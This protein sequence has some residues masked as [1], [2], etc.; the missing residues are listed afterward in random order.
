MKS[1]KFVAIAIFSVILTFCS[2]KN[3]N[4]VFTEAQNLIA[5]EKYDEAVIK[6]EE[7]VNEFP[8]SAKADSSLFE[9][10]KLYQGQVIKN[11]RPKESLKKAVETYKKVF[12]D[13]PNSKLAESSIF[14]AGFILANELKEFKEAGKMYNLYIQKYPNGELADDAKIELQ[15]LGKS[16]EEILS[17]KSI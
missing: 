8:K 5:S 16:P 14:M 6:F 15:N 13:Y 2:N 7:V 4:Q 9:V 17:H 10:A 12:A 3:E 11:L 1:I